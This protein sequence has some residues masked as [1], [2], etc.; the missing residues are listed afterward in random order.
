M[1]F[2]L[3]LALAVGCGPKVNPEG[4]ATEPS[5]NDGSTSKPDPARPVANPPLREVLIGEMCP[6]ASDGRPGLMP[7][8]MRRISWD[9]DRERMGDVLERNMA[10]QF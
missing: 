1:R 5:S 6:A 2:A 7:T 9:D 8:Y 4:P 10:R 3:I